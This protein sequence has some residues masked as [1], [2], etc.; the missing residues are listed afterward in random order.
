MEGGAWI[1]RSHG[2]AGLFPAPGLGLDP[3]LRSARRPPIDLLLGNET[4]GRC[5]AAQA[6]L[7]GGGAGFRYR[8]G[9][10]GAKPTLALQSQ[11]CRH[12]DASALAAELAECRRQQLEAIGLR[13][14]IDRRPADSRCCRRSTS[15]R[16]RVS[17]CVSTG[18][19]RRTSTSGQA[20]STPPR[21]ER[22]LPIAASRLPKEAEVRTLVPGSTERMPAGHK[23]YPLAVRTFDRP[24]MMHFRE[25]RTGDWPAAT[26]RLVSSA[27]VLEL[28][29]RTIQRL[30]S[31][32]GSWFAA[33]HVRR[34]DRARTIPRVG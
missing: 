24:E 21:G 11:A 10:A 3:I 1:A 17:G 9:C 18:R 6:W 25:V 27:P 28:M 15:H 16:G 14:L 30:A 29:R 31:L 4:A 19:G 13:A 2:L 23:P 5:A 12:G 26:V 32:D 20:K 33:V 22:P 7:V 34:G 8:I